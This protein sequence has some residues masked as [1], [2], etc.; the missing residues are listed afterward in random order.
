MT[1]F[2]AGDAVALRAQFVAF[3]AQSAKIVITEASGRVRVLWVPTASLKAMAP[4]PPPMTPEEKE[5]QD[6]QYMERGP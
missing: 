2:K 6:W 1:E 4:E 3:K 5:Y